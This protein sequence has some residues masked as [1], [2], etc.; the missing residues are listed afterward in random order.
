MLPRAI[1]FPLPSYADTVIPSHLHIPRN[2]LGK[3]TG[4]ILASAPSTTA[5]VSLQLPNDRYS[6][7]AAHY[8]RTHFSTLLAQELEGQVQAMARAK[9]HEIAITLDKVG[10]DTFKIMVPGIREDSPKL[11][12]GDRMMLRPLDTIQHAPA[13]F[14]VEAEVVGLDKMK[15]AIYIKSTYLADLHEGIPQDLKGNRKYQIEFKISTDTVCDLQDAVSSLTQICHPTLIVRYDWLAK[16][17]KV[18]T[19]LPLNGYGLNVKI[20]PCF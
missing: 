18:S 17:F 19:M 12:I 15:G 20:T 11:A 9:I 13:P 7:D 5:L 3:G 6:S 10:A 14:V 8:Y 4:S 1:P 16:P 2:L